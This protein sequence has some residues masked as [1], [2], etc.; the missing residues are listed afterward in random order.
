MTKPQEGKIRRD[1]GLKQLIQQGLDRRRGPQQISRALPSAFPDEPNRHL[2]HETA[3]L[4]HRGGPAWNASTACCARAAVPGAVVAAPMNA[5]RASSTRVP[6][7]PTSGGGGWPP[8]RRT[9]GRRPHRRQGQPPDH[10][11]TGR[12]HHPPRQAA[13]PAGRPRCPG[14]RHQT[15]RGLRPLTDTDLGY[16]VGWRLRHQQRPGPAGV[17]DR[18]AGEG[19][20][21]VP[22]SARRREVRQPW[23]AQGRQ[24]KPEL[25]RVSR[26]CSER[27]TCGTVLDQHHPQLRNTLGA[28]PATIGGRR[29]RARGHHPSRPWTRRWRI[30]LSGP[31]GSARRCGSRRRTAGWCPGGL[32][33]SAQGVV[34]TDAGRGHT[35]RGPHLGDR[36]PCCAAFGRVPRRC[37]PQPTWR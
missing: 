6:D 18:R 29:S 14:A 22:A 32:R 30:E 15:C 33:E 37:S 34:A 2:A 25:H 4:P 12:P 27:G 26:V 21:R 24:G 20:K 1:P 31:H 28:A 16:V 8:G 3:Y 11:H 9:G 36:N 13:V 7:Q 17:A 10:R 35:V 19:G 23:Q 5:P